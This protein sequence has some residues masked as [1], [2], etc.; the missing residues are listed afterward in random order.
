MNKDMEDNRKWIFRQILGHQGPLTKDDPD[1]KGSSVNVKI[2]WENREI[3][4]E[5][6]S[7]ISIDDPSIC[8]KYVEKH[9]IDDPSICP[10]Y[11]EKHGQQYPWVEEVQLTSQKTKE[12]V[13]YGQPSQ[14]QVLLYDHQGHVRH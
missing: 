7:I 5:P 11:V 2:Q 6:L 3:T 13:V 4:H 1:Y 8:P 10:K 12:D 14:T 9:P